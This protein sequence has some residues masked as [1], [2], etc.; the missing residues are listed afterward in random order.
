MRNGALCKEVG[1]RKFDRHPL[2]RTIHKVHKIVPPIH[3][4]AFPSPL[5]PPPPHPGRGGAG[6]AGAPRGVRLRLGRGPIRRPRPE[7]HGAWPARIRHGGNTLVPDFERSCAGGS[8]ADRGCA[9]RVPS[10]QLVWPLL[11]YYPSPSH[12]LACSPYI[13]IAMPPR[14]Q[15]RSLGAARGR[16]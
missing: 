16:V 12:L 4:Y 13:F 1:G 8:P 10:L 2:W 6:R 14:S 3:R 15:T 7:R 5:P 11:R 9:L